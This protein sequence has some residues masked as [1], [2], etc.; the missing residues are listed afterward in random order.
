M[1]QALRVGLIGLAMVLLALMGLGAALWAWSAGPTSLATA[2]VQLNRLLPAGLGVETRDV[3]GSVREGGHIGWL[4]WEQDGLHVEAQNVHV[5]WSLASL[6]HKKLHL[7]ELSIAELR[8][9][10]QRT[11]LP[12]AAP[13]APKEL[14]LPFAV[15]ANIRVDSFA[16]TG[17]T[18]QSVGQLSAHY[19]F[20]SDVHRL[21]NGLAHISSGKYQFFGQVQAHDTMALDFHVAGTVHTQVPGG[22]QNLELRAQADITGA[23]AGADATLLLKAQLIPQLAP[24]GGG[25]ASRPAPTQAS[26]S[27]R[28][29]PW[30]KQQLSSAQGQ[31]QALDLSALW[32]QAPQTRLSGQGSVSPVAQGWLANVTLANTLSGPWNSRRLPLQSLDAR[33]AFVSDRWTLQSLQ[34]KGAGGSVTATGWH[35]AGL[36]QGQAQLQ[37]INP[38]AVD[39]RLASTSMTGAVS[40][41]QSASDTRF[42][43]ELQTAATA[44]SGQASARHPDSLQALRLQHLAAKGVWAAPLVTLDALQITA[45]DAQLQGQLAYNTSNQAIQGKLS[46]ALPG[47]QATVDG[48]LASTEGKGQLAVH[49]TDA[50]LATRW[51]ARW[52]EVASALNGAS[53]H[54]AAELSAQW[55]GGW[56]KDA[57]AMQL[58]ASLRVPEITWHQTAA[59]SQIAQAD[60]H[61]RE[62][63]ADASGTLAALTLKTRGLVDA[64]GQRL[65][66][67]GQARLGRM[68]AGLWQAS[69]NQ[70]K[71]AL[72]HSATPKGPWSLQW[73]ESNDKAV[74]LDWSQAGPQR[75]LRVSAGTARLQGPAPGTATVNWQAGQWALGALQRSG[76]WQSQGQVTNLPLAW[77]EAMGGKTL[78]ELGISSNMVLSG[79]WDASQTDTLHLRATLERSA[80][81]LGVR[82]D[83]AQSRVLP[84]GLREAW[85]QLNLDGKQLAGSVRWDSDRMGKAL[86]AFSTRLQTSTGDWGWNNAEPVGGSLQMNLPPVDAWSVL[87][88]PGWRLRGTVNAN[89]GLA[90]T[91]GSPEWSG[92]LQARDLAVRS[93]VDGVDFSRGTL[94]AHL[95]DQQLDIRSFT[96]QGAGGATGGQL[97]M[98]GTVNWLPGNATAPLGARLQMVLTSEAKA[99]RLSSRPDRRVVVSGKLV[100][101]LKESRLSL[102]GALTADQALFTLPEDAAPQLGDDV[103]VRRAKPIPGTPT[104]AAPANGNARSSRTIQ[105]DVLIELDPGPDFQVRGR[106][107]ETRLAGKLTLSAKDSA[108]PSLTGTLRTVRGTYKAYGQRLDIE[109]GVLHFSGPMDNPSLTILAIRPKLTQRVGVQ[110]S[111]SALSPLVRLYAEPDM[112]DA[113][114][115]AWLV[116]GRSADGGGAEAALMQQAALAL[117]GSNGK[118]LSASLTQALGLD[119]L[120][121]RGNANG[122]D[123]ASA[124]SITL[125]KRLSSDF[126][127]AYES[128]LNGAM[129]VFSIFYDLT[130]HL[131]L[132]AQTGEQSAIDLIY[133][134]RYD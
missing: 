8:I 13:T 92:T 32:P 62:L 15:D 106:G 87:A 88:P 55:Q 47:L 64:A 91:L 121:I 50:L 86:L 99:L 68:N 130:R 1:K 94:D 84:A 22:S 33:L 16:L 118:N 67:Q 34:A 107:L 30:Q 122:T 109:Q 42:E 100:A 69:I 61:L 46:L 26:V 93:A 40:A 98:T 43:A 51:L 17:N 90:G 20:D 132:R 6:L 14:S 115:L 83:D 125:G 116:L 72:Q 131:T 56:Q 108:P 114:K 112:P 53:P 19:T 105:P 44:A 49:L 37:G 35:T 10:D 127:V 3:S 123:S 36:W 59:S 128:S 75:T 27:A 63:Q 102:R 54:G 101:E 21:D 111:G 2:L 60:W 103:L 4:L 70:F 48:Q 57:Q 117:L 28:L 96:L 119:E 65:D 134:L 66:W 133:T 126:Y 95:H 113:D 18:S 24:T 74:T 81:D 11:S 9:D 129:G 77:L 7:T 31:W 45:Q 110:I 124:A 104:R 38:A 73:D 120:S 97:A 79:A 80:G 41:R 52:P 78:A 58:Q 71:V 82:M 5:Q 39:S 85:M 89:I 12:D 23:L 25:Q 29:A 76:R